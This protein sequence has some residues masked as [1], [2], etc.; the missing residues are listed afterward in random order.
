MKS[1]EFLVNTLRSVIGVQQGDPL[2]PLLFAT[3]LQPLA[4]D[5]QSILMRPD[6]DGN[7]CPSFST[8]YLDDGYVI[9][10]HAKIKEVLQFMRSQSMTG[11]GLHLKLSKCS[12]VANQTDN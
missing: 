12:V 11:S 10:T 3:A 1:T 5:V 4:E 7:Q 9:A 2:G 6:E 8:W